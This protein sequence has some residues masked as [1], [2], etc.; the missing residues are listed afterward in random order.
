MVLALQELFCGYFGLDRLP[1]GTI[2]GTARRGS[3]ELDP[4]LQIGVD[5]S[6]GLV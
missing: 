3:T 5:L 4:G 2:V 1:D 6:L